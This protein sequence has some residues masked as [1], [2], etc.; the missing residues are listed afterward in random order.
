MVAVPARRYG[1]F[2][3]PGLGVEPVR[4]VDL[5]R[6]RVA[7]LAVRQAAQRDLVPLV[8]DLGPGRPPGEAVDGVPVGRLGQWHVVLRARERVTGASEPVRPRR[9]QLP[10]AVR[11]QLVGLIAGDEGGV[12]ER[13]AAQA[14]AEFGHGGAVGA[15][16]DLVLAAGERGRHDDQH[17]DAGHG[18]Q[19]GLG[20]GAA[21]AGRPN[22][23]PFE[24]Q[25]YR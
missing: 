3:E 24:L 10:S 16:L 21:R 12:A 4:R 17:T 23:Q 22:Q 5:D 8:L 13:E 19:R 7:L 1:W 9:Q 15:R 18:A 20:V 11:R 2:P 6:E 25:F 14:R